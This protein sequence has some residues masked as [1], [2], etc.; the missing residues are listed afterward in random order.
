MDLAH[1]IC[2][3]RMIFLASLYSK[4]EVFVW[5]LTAPVVSGERLKKYVFH[6]ICSELPDGP[7]SIVYMHSTVQK[8]DNSPGLS[9][10]RWIYEDLPSVIKERLQIVYFIHPGIRSRLAFATLGRF[11][12]SGG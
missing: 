8:E 6:K 5:W 3:W 11:F 1:I 7:F 4:A 10:L 2:D 12:L 9:I